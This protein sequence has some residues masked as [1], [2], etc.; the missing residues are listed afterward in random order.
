[1]NREEI[2][3][4][5]RICVYFPEGQCAL[6]APY[7]GSIKFY[8]FISNRP[9]TIIRGD[10]PES[11]VGGGSP[12][13][14]YF[15]FNEIIVFRDEFHLF[16]RDLI[17]SDEAAY[18]IMIEFHLQ[19]SSLDRSIVQRCLVLV[20]QTRR[21]LKS[22]TIFDWIDRFTRLIF[23]SF[24]KSFIKD[25]ICKFFNSWSIVEFK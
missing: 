14:N 12:R 4:I 17:Y 16:E 25:K 9:I 18:T 6:H 3:R 1:M 23:Y 22:I 21:C 7:R 5:L 10:N 8:M 19:I 20:D 11:R 13:I 24:F 15:I 2:K